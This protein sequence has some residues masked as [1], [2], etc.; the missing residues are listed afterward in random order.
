MDGGK[1][2]WK[3][4]LQNSHSKL[5]RCQE[6]RLYFYIQISAYNRINIYFKWCLKKKSGRAI[7]GL[8]RRKNNISVDTNGNV[9]SLTRKEE[10]KKSC[11]A[12]LRACVA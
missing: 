11:V 3:D 4:L 7:S 5:R 9:H 6:E 10:E 1:E 8:K 2:V 12:G